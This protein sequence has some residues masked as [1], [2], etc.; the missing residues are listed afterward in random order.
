[1]IKHLGFG[2]EGLEGWSR[3][4]VWNI[5]EV[6]IRR[7]AETSNLCKQKNLQHIGSCR[8]MCSAL[9]ASKDDLTVGGTVR[10]PRALKI[11]EGYL[12]V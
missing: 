1:M 4:R 7:S 6:E 12:Q 5:L 10:D 9:G 3:Y 8:K 2:F 11:D